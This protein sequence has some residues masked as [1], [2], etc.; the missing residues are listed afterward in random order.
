MT[1]SKKLRAILTRTESRKL[2]YLLFPMTIGMLLEIASIG[3]VI[4]AI[5]VITKP[6]IVEIYPQIKPL[7]TLF[8][9]P[10]QATLVAGGMLLLITLYLIKT[11]FLI[12]LSWK[13]NKLVFD[14]RA[15]LSFR[16]FTGYLQQPW[17]FHL[18][19]NSAQLISHATTEV[20]EL[21]SQALLP[22]ILVISEGVVL[23]GIILVLFVIQPL[24]A[25]YIVGTVGIASIGF[26]RLIRKHILRW[27]EARQYHDGLRV[28]HLQ[29]G[30]GGAKDVKLLGREDE[31]F[32]RYHKHNLI[33]SLVS[34]R[35]KTLLEFPRL[36]LE[37]LAVI[38]LA[39]LVLA[40]I[41]QEKSLDAL[42]PTLG[43]FAAA[44]F[45]V[46]PSV[47]RVLGAIQALRYGLPVINTL[48]REVMLLN[49]NIAPCRTKLMAFKSAI[50]IHQVFYQYP[51]T[52]N[53]ALKN[54]KLIIPFG[55]SIGL[56]GVSGSGK[57][58]LVDI[59]LG[60]LSPITGQVKVDGIDIQTNLRGWQDQ[61][62]Y[63]PQ[64]IYLTDDSLRNNVAFG[65]PENRIDDSAVKRAIKAA[66]LEEF[67]N[68]L[69]DGLETLI[70]ERGVCLSGGQRQRIG[71]A[72]AL[73]HDPVILVLD[74][75][76][77][78]LDTNTEKDVMKA[79]NA[80]HG[81]KTLI[82]VAHRLSTLANCDCLYN[83]ENGRISQHDRTEH[84]TKPSESLYQI[85]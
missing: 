66:Q 28:Q 31:F 43:L 51:N 9:N 59:L 85:T 56:I 15:A 76:T 20:N 79:I 13:Q 36:W 35:Q 61:I 45:R 53:S 49:E 52:K 34:Q 18:Q 63:V 69:P 74:E 4:P 57:S 19:R 82:I 27:G 14:I 23:L 38:G 67:I 2:I 55:S 62:G 16:L 37:L 64:S 78:A 81:K 83:M 44:A 5:I 26:Q 58:T 48:S 80:L 50:S 29:Q 12:Y 6:N 84:K 3:M 73:Y 25:M 65:L 54:I 40:M 47:N 42:L 1:I 8:G 39:V 77:S 7:L 22:G 21:I 75:A 24:G 70:G 17:T 71:I 33:S 46:L 10:T 32:A 60:L 68:T 11:M 72:R 41:S 30:L